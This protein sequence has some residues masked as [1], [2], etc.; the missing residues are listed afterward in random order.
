ME[1]LFKGFDNER[2]SENPAQADN[3]S[4]LTCSPSESKGTKV[5]SYS[6]KQSLCSQ[7]VIVSKIAN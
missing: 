1:N 2:N 6:S 3:L 5:K 7:P 4:V